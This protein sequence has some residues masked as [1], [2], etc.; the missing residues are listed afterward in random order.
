MKIYEAPSDF[1]A[2]QPVL[3]AMCLY[4]VEELE[5]SWDGSGDCGEIDDILILPNFFKNEELQPKVKI[6]KTRYVYECVN[7]EYK[8]NKITEN[9]EVPIIRAYEQLI[10]NLLEN[11][12]IDWSNNEGGFG[13]M[14][15]TVKDGKALIACSS[16]RR[17]LEET[18]D[19]DDR[20]NLE[21]Y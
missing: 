15:L 21:E 1:E 3:T 17:I 16:Y 5:A 20:I 8:H 4:G 7:G 18:V 13:R 19:Y 10:Y 14:I 12:G 2:F 6:E 9:V 11:R